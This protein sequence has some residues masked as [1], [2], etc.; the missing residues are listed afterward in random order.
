MA[1]ERGTRINEERLAKAEVDDQ[2]LDGG[3]VGEKTL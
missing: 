1:A 2:L 3:D